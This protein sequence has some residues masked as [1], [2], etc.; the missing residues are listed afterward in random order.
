MFL[1]SSIHKMLSVVLHFK[2]VKYNFNNLTFFFNF[3]SILDKR[4][5]KFCANLVYITDKIFL[6]LYNQKKLF[7][8]NKIK[9]FELNFFIY[10]QR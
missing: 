8:Q 4:L 1:I 10:Q 7:N 3:L 9:N 6:H 5:R 2:T